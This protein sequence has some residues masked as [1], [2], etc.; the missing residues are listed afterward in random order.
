MDQDIC[1]CGRRRDQHYA[2][3]PHGGR[4][5]YCAPTRTVDRSKPLPTIDFEWHWERFRTA[6]HDAGSA[7]EAH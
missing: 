6:E 5:D 7:T 3:A 2:A 4:G 1:A